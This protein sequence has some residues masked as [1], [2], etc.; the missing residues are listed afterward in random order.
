MPGHLP[1]ILFFSQLCL[2]LWHSNQYRTGLQQKWAHW[3]IHSGGT[4]GNYCSFPIQASTTSLEQEDSV[5]LSKEFGRS[6]VAGQG[7]V[8]QAIGTTAHSRRSCF[9]RRPTSQARRWWHARYTWSWCRILSHRRSTLSSYPSSY[10][11]LVLPVLDCREQFV[12]H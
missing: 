3:N 4:I 5:Q 10:H 9:Y 1:D 8:C 7:T 11:Y 6:S 12:L 2:S